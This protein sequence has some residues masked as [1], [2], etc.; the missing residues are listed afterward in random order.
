[1]LGLELIL[2]FCSALI[3]TLAV[4]PLVIRLG[5]ATGLAGISTQDLAKEFKNRGAE[6][7][8]DFRR[9][10]HT[11]PTPRAGGIALVFS[12]FL[13]YG[14][15]FFAPGLNLLF[16]G[17]FLVFLIGTVDDYKSLPATFRLG[18]QVLIAVLAVGFSDLSIPMIALTSEWLIPLPSIAGFGLAVFCIV[19]GINAVNMIDGLDGLA[20]GVVSVGVILLTLIYFT[21]TQDVSLLLTISIPLLGVMIGFLRYNTHPASIFMGDGGSNW[22]GYMTG[23]LL[24]VLLGGFELVNDEGG[25]RF[26]SQFV[27]KQ[28]NHDAVPFI[29]VLLCIAIPIIDT[30]AVML[31]RMCL[32][33]SPLKADNF[34][35]HHTLLRIGLSHSQSVTAVY[36]FALLV[37]VLGI[38]PVLFDNLRLDWVPYAA[39][40]LITVLIPVSALMKDEVWQR[41]FIRRQHYEAPLW[42]QRSRVFARYWDMFN[43]F[44]IYTALFI[45]PLFAGAVHEQIGLAALLFSAVLLASALIRFRSVDFVE[46]LLVVVAA[47]L[48]LLANNQN[49]LII[50]IESVRYNFR[51]V[52]NALFVLLCCS[53]FGYLIYTLKRRYLV[54]GPSDFLMLTLPLVLLLTPEPY[55]SEFHLNI[56][57]MRCLVLFMALRIMLQSKRHRTHRIKMFSAAALFYI[58]ITSVFAVRIVY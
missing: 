44:L 31:R 8:G 49:Q 55:N 37:G 19:G 18:L 7:S 58:G 34:H 38:S 24:I 42:G 13:T 20:A 21:K 47:A 51:D 36:F 10:V 6:K 26:A 32:G 2:S 40:T 15:W 5:A 57:G 25:Y 43:R 45:T 23:V 56:I 54:V 17:S 41:L 29:S 9:H 53:S 39:A 12:F 33:V 48:L 50:E 30:L 16:L 3:V 1:M 4:M 46:H 35:F 14:L 11:R 22:L 28:S 27:T 52:Y